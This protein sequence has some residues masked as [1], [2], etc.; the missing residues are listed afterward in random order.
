MPRKKKEHISRAE[1]RD[2]TGPLAFVALDLE[3][4]GFSPE[5]DQIIELGAAKVAGN[6]VADTFQSLAYT[7]TAIPVPVQRLTGLSNADLEGAPALA[8]VLERATAFI[9]E[10][11]LVMHNA[12]FD[13][14]FLG[15]HLELAN[16]VWDTLVLA[17]MAFP[18]LRNHGLEYLSK[19]FGFHPGR[20]HR[21]LE[22]SLAT[23]RLGLLVHRLLFDYDD[24]LL[25]LMQR[26]APPDYRELLEG[27]RNGKRLGAA[28][29][30][31]FDVSRESLENAVRIG[32]QETQTATRHGTV[33]SI[34]Q[35]FGPGG[36][37]AKAMGQAFERRTEQ[38]TIAAN[39]AEALDDQHFLLV[40]AGTGVGKSMAYLAP[41]AIWARANG[42]RVVISTYTRNL[43]EQLYYKDVPLLRAAIGPFRAALLKGRSNYLCWRKWR[44]AAAYPELFL[45]AGERSEALILA[46]WAEQTRTGDI[47]EHGGFNPGRA[48]GLWAKLC[49]EATSCQGGRCPS[50][51]KCFLV[52]AR[53]AAQE[54]ELVI[55][56]HSLLFTD[57]V[58]QN[59]ILPEYQRLVF[60]EAHN[61]EQVATDYLGYSMNRW[62]AHSFLQ[63]LYSR[64]PAEGG[65]LATLN[66]WVRRTARRG[67]ATATW[68]RSILAA[69]ELVLESGKGADR[70][71]LGKWGETGRRQEKKRYAAGDTFQRE[72]FERAEQLVEQLLALADRLQQLRE[73]LLE[74][75]SGGYQEQEA[76]ADQL[77]LNSMQARNLANT[78]AKLI[79]ADERGFIF[80]AE[81]RDQGLQLVAGPLQVG[82]IIAKEFY[83]NLKTLV[84]TS[85]TLAADRKFDYFRQRSGLA[86]LEPDRVQEVSLASPFD[87]TRQAELLIL[88]YL[89]SPKSD[90]FDRALVKSLEEILRA[91]RTGGL[92][93]FTSFD[94]LNKCYRHLRGAGL[95]VLAQGIDGNPAQLMET[96]LKSR[97]A[98]ILGTS[99]FWEGVDLPGQSLELLVITKL[100]FSVPTDP[101]V[102]ARSQA[103]EREGGSAFQ[104][105]LLPE[106]VIRLRQGFGRLIRSKTDRGQVV[107]CDSRIVNNE[108]GQAFLRSLPVLPT[109]ICERLEDAAEAVRGGNIGGNI[110]G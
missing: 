20:S 27:V 5:S 18:G 68:Q 29:A 67:A 92:V 41:S 61:L 87:F 14:A 30:W 2:E 82:T 55:V 48:P 84:Y 34:A 79:Q 85:A 72:L 58:S 97:T 95:E 45:S 60:D 105:Y 35:V 8:D 103:I 31:P 39:V 19:L 89:P 69:G 62:E 76:L 49:A 23:A 86:L 66:G 88:K 59:R 43:Q 52:R 17:R 15:V 83:P 74:L 101:L 104:Q 36:E 9:G 11:P 21:A 81:F 42:E 70:L 16:L 47:S 1:A 90:D 50:V 73:W 25:E 63:G 33:D 80:W 12:A 13:T 100:P 28:P 51:R 106:A 40:E 38:E 64:R 108:Y 37:L 110:G 3:T 78:L 98:V 6:A 57:L 32:K 94:L 54:S 53:K 24:A 77:G 65:L 7:D 99:S 22:D 56:N 4:T 107:I 102:E 44:E 10:A 46:P 93:L 91:H 96:S 71:F 26:L 109:A 75:E